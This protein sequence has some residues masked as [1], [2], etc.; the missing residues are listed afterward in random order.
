MS[1]M[2]K[3]RYKGKEYYYYKND[4]VGTDF[5]IVHDTLRRELEKQFSSGRNLD[6]MTIDQLL[7]EGDRLK[8]NGSYPRAVG[9]FEKAL[10]KCGERDG[11]PAEI[12]PRLTSCWRAQGFPEKAVDLFGQ[13]I[14]SRSF[15]LAWNPPL[16]TSVGAAFCDLDDWDMGRKCAD[17]AFSQSRKKASEELN[18][19][20]GRIYRHYG[21]EQ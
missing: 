9:C 3:M 2:I 19:L 7:Q 14:E 15:V 16:L 20:Y 18:N 13:L 17:K 4:W 21:Y 8:K 12:Y 1:N 10:S 5:V 6:D 11:R